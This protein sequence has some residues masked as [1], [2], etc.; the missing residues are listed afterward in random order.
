MHPAL[1]KETED[2]D[3]TR[4]EKKASTSINGKLGNHSQTLAECVSRRIINWPV[5]S[6]E[7]KQ[8]LSSLL[9][10]VVATGMTFSSLCCILNYKLL[11]FR[12]VTF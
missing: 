8:R 4:V 5:D 2:V 7:H 6:A 10:M 9:S 11:I 3:K 12:V 1:W